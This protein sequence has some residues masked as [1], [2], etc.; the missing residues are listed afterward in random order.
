MYNRAKELYCDTT[1][2][3]FGFFILYLPKKM[4]TEKWRKVADSPLSYFFSIIKELNFMLVII[5]SC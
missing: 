5:G 1:I 3:V 2:Y 4:E